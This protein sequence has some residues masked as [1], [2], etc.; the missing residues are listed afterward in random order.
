MKNAGFTSLIIKKQK[1]MPLQIWIDADAAP[2]DV[3]EMVFKASGRLKI[4]VV[5]VA[6]LVSGRRGLRAHA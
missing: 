3:K 1:N 2:R 4:A 6:S 5:L